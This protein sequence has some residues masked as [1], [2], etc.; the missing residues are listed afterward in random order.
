M[1]GDHVVRAVCKGRYPGTESHPL[2]TST[3]RGNETRRGHAIDDIAIDVVEK[4]TGC[5]SMSLYSVSAV[6]PST[7]S[8]RV[9]ASVLHEETKINA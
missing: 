4:A 7:C 1:Y 9:W 5:G 8:G 2:L 3:M 6:G